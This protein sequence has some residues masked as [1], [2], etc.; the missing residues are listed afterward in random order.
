VLQ[1]RQLGPKG[2]DAAVEHAS[3]VRDLAFAGECDVVPEAAVD[4]FV[5]LPAQRREVSLVAI[6]PSELGEQLADATFC[7][8]PA[9]I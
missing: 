7:G 9:C 3:L 4:P 1:R 6:E 8:H 2:I 5:E